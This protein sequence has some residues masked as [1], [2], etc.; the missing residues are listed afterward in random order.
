MS[1]GPLQREP[2]NSPKRLP[3]PPLSRV[4]VRHLP[5]TCVW[6]AVCMVAS[7]IPTAPL[8][9][10]ADDEAASQ[11]TPIVGFRDAM[12]PSHPCAP[13]LLRAT[14]SD[15]SQGRSEPRHP[16]PKLT[17]SRTQEPIGGT[18]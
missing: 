2:G 7:L 15:R 4:F 5:S 16:D 12:S 14:D 13:R 18:G 9:A 17:F 8:P 11:R 3:I 10:R 6:I 1:S